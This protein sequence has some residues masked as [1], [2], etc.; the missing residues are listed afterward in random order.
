MPDDIGELFKNF[1]YDPQGSKLSRS[2]CIFYANYGGY[3]WRAVFE[4]YIDSKPR[5]YGVSSLEYP[6]VVDE[7][8]GHM[9][10]IAETKH[11]T[12]IAEKDGKHGPAFLFELVEPFG[13]VYKPDLPSSSVDRV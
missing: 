5:F 13:I 12:L 6:E 10:S 8:L 4:V 7:E 9:M 2:R 11:V 3:D 1:S